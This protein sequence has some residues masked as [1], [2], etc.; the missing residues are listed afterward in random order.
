MIRVKKI[1]T[2]RRNRLPRLTEI[3]N[4]N[5]KIEA[6]YIFGSYA[7]NKIKPLS[8]IDIAVLLKKNVYRECL[9]DL[10]IELL[11]KA[12]SVLGTEEI[13]FVLLNEAPYELAFNILKTGKILLCHNEKAIR[14]FREK[15]VLNY[16]DTRHLRD[17]GFFHLMERIKNER[18]GYDEGRR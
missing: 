14:E 15:T 1:E 16:L 18:F 2:E 4:G 9:F 11:N 10:K 8:D 7:K 3:F 5:K 12:V 6:Y 17:E 13:D